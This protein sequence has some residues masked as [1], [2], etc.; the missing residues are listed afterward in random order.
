MDSAG[1]AGGLGATGLPR[2]YLGLKPV[3]FTLYVPKYLYGSF[4]TFGYVLIVRIVLY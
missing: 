3:C 1:V 4:R 2:G